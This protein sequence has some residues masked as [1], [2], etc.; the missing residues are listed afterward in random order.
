MAP[1]FYSSHID[2]NIALQLIPY[3][4]PKD[5]DNKSQFVTIELKVQAGNRAGANQKYKKVIRTFEGGS[6]KEFV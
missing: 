1:T 3:E 6:P 2:N 5:E 4:S